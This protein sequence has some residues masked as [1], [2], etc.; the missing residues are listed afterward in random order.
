VSRQL[1]VFCDVCR[2]P[3]MGLNIPVG[4]PGTDGQIPMKPVDLCATH[5]ANEVK[6][7]LAELPFDARLEWIA[8]VRSA[9]G[10][11]HGG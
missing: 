6:A 2:G 10:A 11:R 5:L 8:R 9:Q 7:F 4:D 1:N 3:A